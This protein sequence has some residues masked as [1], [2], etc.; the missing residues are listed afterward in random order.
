MCS[1]PWMLD[2]PVGQALA[3]AKLLECVNGKSIRVSSLPLED[4]R[5][6]M[7]LVLA[8]HEWGALRTLPE[9]KKNSKKKQTEKALK[10]AS[11]GTVK[12]IDASKEKINGGPKGKKKTGKKSKVRAQ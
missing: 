8:L 3:V 6:K 4:D 9:E 10:T 1:M 5:E 7:E 11:Q 12:K 2:I